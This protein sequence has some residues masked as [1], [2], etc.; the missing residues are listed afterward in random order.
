[1]DDDTA[2]QL[3]LDNLEGE[4]LAPP[5]RLSFVT[6]RRKQ[7]WNRN[8][9]ALGLSS[10]FIEPLES[11]S[12]HFIQAGIAR[13]I[14]LFP[15]KRFDPVERDE[16]NR[17]IRDLYEDVRDFIV[18]HYKAT[19]RDDTPFWDH[20]RNMAVP[21]SLQ[22]KID[23]FRAKGRVFREGLELFATTSWVAVALGQH[24]VPDEYE[25]AVDALDETK[26]AIALDQMHEEYRQVAAQL[27]T[28]G[29]FVRHCCATAP[30]EPS[31]PPPAPETSPAAMPTFSFESESP[32]TGSESPV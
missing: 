4:P 27:P 22:R 1:M 14:A 30:T 18:L 25:P 31:R 11:T 5:R 12:I 15:D 26:V 32:F 6:G 29:D 23:L 19:R 9:I 28:H 8:V 20:C 13:L 3:L 10:G 7:S 24:V 21:E 16:F 17:Q 2:K